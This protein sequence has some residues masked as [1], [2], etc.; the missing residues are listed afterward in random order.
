M[1]QEEY[2]SMGKGKPM[3]DDGPTFALL[4]L[5]LSVAMW[6]YEGGWVCLSN[7]IEEDM[8]L[9]VVDRQRSLVPLVR[10]GVAFQLF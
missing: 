8:S 7:I 9:T 1:T 10:H 3:P 5:L 6:A 2:Y 4:A